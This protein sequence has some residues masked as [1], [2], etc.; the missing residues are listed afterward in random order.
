MWI[1]DSSRNQE[2]VSNFGLNLTIEKQHLTGTS[3]KIFY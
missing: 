1:A 2:H 3:S